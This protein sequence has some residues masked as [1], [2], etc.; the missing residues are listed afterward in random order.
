MYFCNFVIIYLPLNKDWSLNLKKKN[1]NPLSSRMLCAM[2]GWNLLK[3]FLR[4]LLN[5]VIVYSLFR[6]NLPIEKGMTLH[7]NKHESPS[8]RDV[9]CQVWLNMIQWVWRR[10]IFYLVK[11]FL[12]FLYYL[13]LEKDKALHLNKLESPLPKDALYQV[14]MKMAL[15]F[16]KRKVY[17]EKGTD[18]RQSEKLN[19]AFSS[20]ELRKTTG[21]KWI[22]ILHKSYFDLSLYG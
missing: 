8:P 13:P 19:W 6:Y 20:G 17:T 21:I 12:L 5:F 4:R 3:W 15:W 9:Y 16:W 14:W 7:L 2:F 11:V 1:L 18:V 10:R 22:I